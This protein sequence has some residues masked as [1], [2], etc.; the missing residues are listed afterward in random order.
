MAYYAEFDIETGRII[1]RGKCQ[2]QRVP[3]PRRSNAIALIRA[4]P[5]YNAVICDK[6]N[7][8]KRAV[9]PKLTR[10]SFDKYKKKPVKILEGKR[11]AHITNEQWQ[12]VL[13]RLD[14]LENR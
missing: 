8:K 5:R 10:K 9:N 1:R 2:A 11:P 7:K 3:T 6:I 12:A 13:K 4:D 14:K